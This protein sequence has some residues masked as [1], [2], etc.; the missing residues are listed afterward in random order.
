MIEQLQ[1]VSV[2]P[3][4]GIFSPAFESHKHVIIVVLILKFRSCGSCGVGDMRAVNKNLRFTFRSVQP[5]LIM[6][7]LLQVL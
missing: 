4:L 2:H 5:E 6:P 1:Q 7:R 3:W